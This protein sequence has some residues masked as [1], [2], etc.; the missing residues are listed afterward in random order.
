M[1]NIFIS[2]SLI[3]PAKSNTS[4]NMNQML[5]YQSAYSAVCIF[6]TYITVILQKLLQ[7]NVKLRYN[8]LHFSFSLHLKT[9]NLFLEITTKI[10]IPS[11]PIIYIKNTQTHILMVT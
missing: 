4:N 2:Y 9:L 10:N 3:K 5:F 1:K 7:I 11:E 8:C 6:H